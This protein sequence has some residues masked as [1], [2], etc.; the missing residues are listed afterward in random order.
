MPP[1]QSID[2]FARSFAHVLVQ[3]FIKE[4]NIPFDNIAIELSDDLFLSQSRIILDSYQKRKLE[5]QYYRGA[6]NTLQGT[7][8]FEREDVRS[9]AHA[10]VLY[11]ITQYQFWATTAI[12]EI[13]HIIDYRLFGQI[14]NLNSIEHIEKHRHYLL[15]YYWTEFHAKNVSIKYFEGFISRYDNKRKEAVFNSFQNDETENILNEIDAFKDD[16]FVNLNYHLVHYLAILNAY[17]D[18][19]GFALET[20][21]N[22]LFR[23]PKPTTDLLFFFKEY[24]DLKSA[25][26]NFDKLESIIDALDQAIIFRS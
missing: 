1:E 16:N 5:T 12:H 19:Y 3:K 11:D 2:E 10:L 25:F 7:C 4:H 21:E 15:F 17:F 9:K 6:Y 8:C 23:F 14:I 20:M 22:I 26:D 13:L 18:V 24:N